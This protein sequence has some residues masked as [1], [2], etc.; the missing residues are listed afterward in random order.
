MKV[1]N[2]YDDDDDNDDHHEGDDD[3]NGGGGDWARPFHVKNYIIQWLTCDVADV[4]DL[5]QICFTHI[6]DIVCHKSQ[7]Q[8][9]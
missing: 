8:V 7:L 6:Q 9:R 3:D 4:D 2:N 1:L 5:I